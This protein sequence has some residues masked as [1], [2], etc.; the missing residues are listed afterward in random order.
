MSEP[1][2]PLR[3]GWARRGTETT[4][5]SRAA[6]SWPRTSSADPPETSTC[7]RSTSS[8]TPST[9]ARSSW[10]SQQS[11]LRAAL[12]T[13]RFLL[14]L[15]VS[16][17]DPIWPEPQTVRLPGLLG[18]HVDVIGHPLATVIAEKTVTVLQRGTQST[19]WRDF[20]DVRALA[21]RYPFVAGELAAAGAAVSVHRGQELGAL[22]AV[23]EGYGALAQGKWT[24]WV[25]SNGLQDAV[26]ADLDAQVAAVVTFIDPVY[27]G[28]VSEDATWDPVAFSW[29]E[30][31]RV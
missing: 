26:E 9:C 25:A 4:S 8:L 28:T 24:A 14:K 30:P 21:R 19:R 20:V 29:S 16:T 5:S 11:T 12:N 22:A 3:P 13:Y 6:S 10:Q 27:L 17:G 2:L 1:A 7:R 23:T 18:G 31:A 15:D